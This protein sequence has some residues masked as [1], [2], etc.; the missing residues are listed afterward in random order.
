MRMRSDRAAIYLAD[1]RRAGL[2][3]FVGVF[4]ADPV[5]DFVNSFDK[6]DAD[7]AVARDA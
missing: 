2:F 6:A 5:I 7:W 1:L 3:R 4:A